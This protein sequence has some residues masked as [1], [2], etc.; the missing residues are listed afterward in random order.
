MSQWQT[1]FLGIYLD[2]SL[3]KFGWEVLDSNLTEVHRSL[4]TVFPPNVHRRRAPPCRESLHE[5]SGHN[6]SH[7]APDS[8]D[9]ALRTCSEQ[10]GRVGE[11]S[12]KPSPQNY[13]VIFTNL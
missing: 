13:S 3:L 12:G 6:F 2:F 5:N 4:S 7:V 1:S 10:E 11:T 9:I 8:L